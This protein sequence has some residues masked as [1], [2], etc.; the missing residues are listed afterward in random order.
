M[1]Y[2]ILGF[3]LLIYLFMFY[4]WKATNYHWDASLDLYQS[5]GS[6]F[7]VAPLSVEH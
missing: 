1:S 6:Y 4:D 3:F 2:L 5:W 7:M